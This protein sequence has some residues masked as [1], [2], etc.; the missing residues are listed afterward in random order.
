MTF[1]LVQRT[2]KINNANEHEIDLYLG[3]VKLSITDTNIFHP[4]SFEDVNSKVA[5]YGPEVVQ[6]VVGKSDSIKS[7]EA[8]NGNG[9]AEFQ[10]LRLTDLSA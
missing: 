3:S 1:A 10:A 9:L 8:V 7:C 5:A 4:Y 6:M 2:I